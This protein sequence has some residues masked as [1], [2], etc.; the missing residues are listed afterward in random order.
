VE[1]GGEGVTIGWVTE[2]EPVTK[3]TWRRG[4]NSI[5][6]VALAVRERGKSCQI[7]KRRNMGQEEE[8]ETGWKTRC[9]L[10]EFPGGGV[11]EANLCPISKGGEGGWRKRRESGRGCYRRA[12]GWTETEA[13]G[14]YVWGNR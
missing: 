9:F 1:E 7:T 2:R 13:A 8:K 11:S 5:V 4:G 12:K 3:T 14:D 10:T 6:E